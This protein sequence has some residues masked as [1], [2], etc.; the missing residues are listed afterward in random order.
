MD[1]YRCRRLRFASA[2]GGANRAFQTKAPPR[3]LGWNFFVPSGYSTSLMCSIPREIL[4]LS[5]PIATS[6]RR[7]MFIL[8]VFFYLADMKS[9]IG[10]HGNWFFACTHSV[11]GFT[12]TGVSAQ[13]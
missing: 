1:S 13:D 4:A 7:H 9:R 2:G 3:L 5:L 8:C 6:L 12:N 10:H 11:P